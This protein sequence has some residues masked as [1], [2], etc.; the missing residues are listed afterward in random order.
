MPLGFARG[1]PPPKGAGSPSRVLHPANASGIVTYSVA[2]FCFF[3][4]ILCRSGFARDPPPP[5][6]AGSPVSRVLHPANAS[7]IVTYSVGGT[8]PPC[9]LP[10]ASSLGIGRVLPVG[11][12]LTGRCVLCIDRVLPV[13]L[14]DHLIRYH[15]T[16]DTV[17]TLP[18]D[19][20][21]CNAA[22]RTNTPNCRLRQ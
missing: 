7:G 2:V 4:G 13:A 18:S 22:G 17:S 12:S 21:C 8:S 11:N 1:P 10:G 19:S 20:Q 15:E 14:V 16:E 9:R 3:L 5:K 6:G